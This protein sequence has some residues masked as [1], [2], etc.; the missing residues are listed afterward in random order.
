MISDGLVRAQT[1]PA[2]GRPRRLAGF[3][4]AVFLLELPRPPERDIRHLTALYHD[5]VRLA[6]RVFGDL[7]TQF[8][9]DLDKRAT[10]VFTADHGEE[11]GEHGGWK[12]GPS[13]F[14]EILRTRK[15]APAALA[16]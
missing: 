6:D 13:L 5:E 10:V 14:D 11:L 9:Q 7:W 8:D 4:C 15:A 2:P 12:H 1:D 16:A 3:V